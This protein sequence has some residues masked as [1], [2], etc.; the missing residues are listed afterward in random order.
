MPTSFG[1]SAAA[2]AA[3]LGCTLFATHASAAPWG[4]RLSYPNDPTTQVGIGYNSDDATDVE[5]HFGTSPNALD[6]TLVVDGSE[7]FTQAAELGFAFSATLSGLSP[8]TT[9]YYK[10]GREGALHPQGAPYAFTTLPDDRCA[11]FR[12]V[13]IGDNRSNINGVGASAIYPGILEA[14]AATTPNF[15]VN[16]GDMVKNGE[17]AEE[18]RDFLEKSESA[19]ARIPSLP[20]MG[21]HDADDVDGDAAIYNQLFRLPRNSQTV[22]EDYY[23]IDVGPVH[24]VSLNSQFTNATELPQQVAWLDADLA[25]NVQPW[26]LIF[27]HKA[28]YT[29]GNHVTGEESDGALNAAFVPVFDRHNVDLVFNG[30]SHDYERYAPSVGVDASFGGTG[31]TF[32]AGNGQTIAALAEIPN[33]DVGTT[34]TVTGGGGAATLGAIEEFLDECPDPACTFCTGLNIGGC[35]EDVLDRDRDGTVVFSGDHHFVVLD[36]V[37]D[38]LSAQV[39]STDD[40]GEILDAWTMRKEGSGLN[41]AGPVDAGPPPAVEDAGA[42]G[43]DGGGDEGDTDSGPSLNEPDPVTPGPVTPS[44]ESTPATPAPSTDEPESEPTD[45]TASGCGCDATPAAPTEGIV[46][47]LLAGLALLRRRRR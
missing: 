8:D 9:Y 19:F 3:I 7:I 32:P 45:P 26:T 4:V 2:F 17:A 42:P 23:S 38:T 31:R 20:T 21:N 15:F 13:L 11:A 28:I 41:C 27:F 22:T 12:A 29:R 18:W 14:A 34:Y 16:T 39:I 33:G 43:V 10:V 6:Q 40:P 35:D 36:V 24:F 30:H 44:P 47:G 46:L 25:A 1:R 37:G 5:I